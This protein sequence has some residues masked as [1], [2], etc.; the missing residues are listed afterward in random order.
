MLFRSTAKLL[1]Q[2]SELVASV[3]V[4]TGN[5]ESTSEA[6][7][8]PTG[9]IPKL[10]GDKNNA[11][12]TKIIGIMADIE[13]SVKSLQSIISNLN[14]EVPKIAAILNESRLAIQKAQ[15]VL[16]GIKNNPLIKGGIPERQE[17]QSLYQ[18]M[19]EGGIE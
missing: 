18:S 14:S 7:K 8:D 19:R 13:K 9:L 16:E 15:D 4:I 1:D 17:Q 12:Y 2:V 10:L 3:N 11:M 5:F 6:L